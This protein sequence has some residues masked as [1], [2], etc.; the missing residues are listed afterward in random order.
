MGGDAVEP[1]LEAFVR[2]VGHDLGHEF[3]ILYNTAP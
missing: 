1:G 2:L 3:E